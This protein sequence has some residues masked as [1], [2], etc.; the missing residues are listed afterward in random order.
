MQNMKQNICAS[1]TAFKIIT[2]CQWIKTFA[3]AW[4]RRR[5]DGASRKALEICFD[6]TNIDFKDFETRSWCLLKDW[7]IVKWTV[8]LEP[9]VTILSVHVVRILSGILAVFIKR[10]YFRDVFSPK[11]NNKIAWNVGANRMEPIDLDSWRFHP[12]WWHKLHRIPRLFGVQG[13]GQSVVVL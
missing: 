11:L 1:W 8:P 3:I 6:A 13:A 12:L 7:R 10:S 2:Y 5:N 4:C 9:G